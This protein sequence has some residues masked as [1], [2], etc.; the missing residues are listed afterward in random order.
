MRH[1]RLL[2]VLVGVALL[3]ASCNW[4]L[5]RLGPD[6]TGNDT[7][8]T[9]ISSGNVSQ[10]TQQWTA[11][12]GGPGSDPIVA[13][14]RVFVTASTAGGQLDAFDAPG[15]SN[16]TGTATK[17]CQPVWSESVPGAVASEAPAENSGSVWLGTNNAN[18]GSMNEYNESTGALIPPTIT[19]GAGLPPY[20]TPTSPAVANNTV[21]ASLGT[22]PDANEPGQT[23]PGLEAVEPV[24]ATN[25]NPNRAT[26]VYFR[27]AGETNAPTVAS[28]TLYAVDNSTHTFEAFDAAAVTNCLLNGPFP[29]FDWLCL[30]LWTG[31]IA[32]TATTF[33]AVANGLVYV[34][35]ST[36]TLY[37]F[38]AGGC[39]AATCSPA[40]TAKTNGAIESSPAVTSTT[41]F[42][43]SDDGS[44]YAFPANGCGAAT[45]QPLWTAS[46]GG[47]VKSSPSVGGDV[48]YVG[49]DDGNLYAFNASGCGATSCQALVKVSVGAPVETSPAVANGQVFA[50]DTAGTLHA[51]GL[52]ASGS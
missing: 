30:P 22:V 43:G 39:G 48:V 20:G 31:S 24:G 46:T 4:P 49:S 15:N 42:V 50:T 14:G 44:L 23:E 25:G 5:D 16:C 33:Q 26:F 12:L 6:R 41:A 52:P 1:L 29:G 34:G 8:E 32:G 7:L 13:N 27:T 45:C 10:L 17:T 51:Y 11:S 21:Y 40:W 28:G 2:G 18:G 35:D 19:L 9:I 36:G 47:A 38:P 3:A 37:A